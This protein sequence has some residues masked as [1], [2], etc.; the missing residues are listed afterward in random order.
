MKALS[1][2]SPQN[3]NSFN[4]V[5]NLYVCLS[6]AEEKKTASIDSCRVFLC[7]MKITFSQHS[8]KYNFY[9]FSTERK[10]KTG[11]LKPVP[12]RLL[13]VALLLFFCLFTGL[14]LYSKCMPLLLV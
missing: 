14:F 8:S 11:G 4:Q 5:I 2:R 13:K 1:D 7:N 6:S 12:L 9:V 10:K 3:I